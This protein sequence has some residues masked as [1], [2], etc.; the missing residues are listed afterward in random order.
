MRLINIFAF[1]MIAIS[2]SACSYPA[3]QTGGAVTSTSANVMGSAHSKYTQTPYIRSESAPSHG[4]QKYV[5]GV[6]LSPYIAQVNVTPVF[7]PVK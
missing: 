1:L 4:M 6:M 7:I 2:L 5:K 3:H